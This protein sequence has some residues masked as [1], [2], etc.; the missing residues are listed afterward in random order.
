MSLFDVIKYNGVNP[1]DERELSQLPERLVL[2]YC[3][4]YSG[5]D[6]APRHPHWFRCKMLSTQSDLYIANAYYQSALKEYANELV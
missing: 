6:E 2:L 3:S 1:V 5:W 4:R